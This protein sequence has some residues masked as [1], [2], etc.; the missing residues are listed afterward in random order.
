M[1]T[2]HTL[3]RRIIPPQ[4]QD[5]AMT[6]AK[7]V[8]APNARAKPAL[9]HHHCG[10][11]DAPIGHSPNPGQEPSHLRHCDQCVGRQHAPIITNP[12]APCR[13]AGG[14]SRSADHGA[15]VV[16]SRTGSNRPAKSQPTGAV[17]SPTRSCHP[18]R[19]RSGNRPA[20]LNSAPASG[21]QPRVIAFIIARAFARTT[22][23]R[24]T[25]LA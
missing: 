8:A 5:K 11:C 24:G 12:L 7:P 19:N 6:T 2:A 1:T 18:C 17:T 3:I 16:A 4:H 10:H 15:V 9:H 23:H 14:H 22:L 21:R 25:Q 13:C 20:I